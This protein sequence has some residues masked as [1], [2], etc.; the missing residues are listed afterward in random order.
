MH[1]LKN[2]DLIKYISPVEAVNSIESGSRVFLHGS[3]ATPVSLVNALLKRYNELENV[4]L[5]S[6]TN[7][8]EINFDKP[9]Y[10]GSFF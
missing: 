6:I 2:A 10:A 8:G 1:N 9:E 3:A 7:L 4:E 5:V